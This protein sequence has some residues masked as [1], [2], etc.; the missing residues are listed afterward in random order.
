MRPT[1]VKLH[2]LR[3]RKRRPVV[4]GYAFEIDGIPLVVH[5]AFDPDTQ[6]QVARYAWRVTEPRTGRSLV[7]AG[8]AAH[9]T[10]ACMVADNI[11]RRYGADKIRQRIEDQA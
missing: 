11:V 1:T 6:K 5:R 4:K 10:G 3:G 2:M 7:G 9:R 8:I